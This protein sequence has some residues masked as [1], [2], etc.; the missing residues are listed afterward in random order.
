M[1]VGDVT[2][3]RNQGGRIPQC[4]YGV[5]GVV[6]IES[7]WDDMSNVRR[8]LLI[9]SARTASL[10]LPTEFGLREVEHESTLVILG[11]LD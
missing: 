2:R 7:C 9:S 6:R 5:E 3:P 10:V 8:M 1:G 4:Y 11:R